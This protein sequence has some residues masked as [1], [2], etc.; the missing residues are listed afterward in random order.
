VLKSLEAQAGQRYVSPAD[1]ARVHV[2]LG[3]RDRAFALLEK[4]LEER[5]DFFVNLKVDPR[6]DA[7]RD[8]SRFAALRARVGLAAD[9]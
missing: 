1:L 6:L 5:S 3:D 4:A 2:A 9:R 8:D 7:L